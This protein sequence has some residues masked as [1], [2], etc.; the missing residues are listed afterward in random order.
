MIHLS[1]RRLAAALALGLLALPL[2]PAAPASA[3]A[4][5][6]CE[7]RTV[8]VNLSAADP[9]GYQIAGWACWVGTAA[10]KPVELL[11]P[12]FTYDHTYWDFPYQ[13]DR[14]SYVRAAT[15]AKFVTFAIDR[16]GTGQSSYPPSSLL[17]AQAHEYAL[18]QVVGYLRGAFPGV[19]VVAVG[20]SAGSG[21]VL[22]EAS[23]FADVDAVLLTGLLH[24]PDAADATFFG[25]FYPASLDPRFAGSGYDLGY[26]TTEPGTRGP[27]FY[28]LLVAD[29]LVIANDELLKSTGSSTELSSG[30]TSLLLTTSSAIHV[31]VMLAVGQDD[32]SFC[33]T[34]LGMSCDSTADVLSREALDWSAAACLSAFVLPSSGHDINLHPNASLWFAAAN[35]WV[36][37]HAA[38]TCS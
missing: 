23:D 11:V 9:T 32:A 10:H 19:P 33:N 21:T 6:T 24:V 8:P 36:S 22:Q 1:Q 26:L 16:L 3:N 38:G 34:T 7:Y 27:V 31:P 28:N 35:D 18:H 5:P 37:R 15:N 4:T 13:P 29:P 14:Y 12:G 17:T 20:H 2:V 30:D 25:S